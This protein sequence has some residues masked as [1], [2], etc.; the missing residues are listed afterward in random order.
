MC[1]ACRQGYVK[2]GGHGDT[3]PV[4]RRSFTNTITAM[5]QQ[6]YMTLPRELHTKT[7]RTVHTKIS[8]SFPMIYRSDPSK[9]LRGLS[10]L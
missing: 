5:S 9:Q 6:L 1:Q 3:M 8:I 10:E 4:S 7:L 2:K